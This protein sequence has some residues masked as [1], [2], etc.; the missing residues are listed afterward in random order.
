MSPRLAQ[1]Q[2]ELARLANELWEAQ[3]QG[4]DYHV[5]NDLRRE[6]AYW[7]DQLDYAEDDE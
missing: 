6:E 4:E 7:L 1:V 5:I 2:V 3:A